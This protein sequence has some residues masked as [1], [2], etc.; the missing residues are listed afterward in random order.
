M[1]SSDFIIEIEL[2]RNLPYIKYSVKSDQ[3]IESVS[4]S[5]SY[6]HCIF[7]YL[8]ERIHLFVV[9]YNL[10]VVYQMIYYFHR[11]EMLCTSALIFNR[12]GPGTLI[13]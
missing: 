12:A 10:Q 3:I 7:C 2:H 4:S 11:A 1:D 13:L 5:A 9:V 6:E 8:Y